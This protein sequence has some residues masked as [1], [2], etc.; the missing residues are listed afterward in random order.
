VNIHRVLLIKLLF[1]EVTFLASGIDLTDS[2]QA[3]LAALDIEIIFFYKCRAVEHQTNYLLNNVW[4]IIDW[5][6]SEAWKHWVF[7]CI[8]QPRQ[9]S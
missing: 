1:P 5:G 8:C 9:V 2:G 3:E 4:Y 6:E 7:T